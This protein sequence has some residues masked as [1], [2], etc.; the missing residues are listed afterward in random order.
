MRIP[1]TPKPSIPIPSNVTQDA[2][3]CTYLGSYLQANEDVKKEISQVDKQA[4]TLP[5]LSK[6]WSL[7]IYMLKT[8]L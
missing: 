8:K 6:I 5:R 4:V 1:V 3:Q 7:K 2:K